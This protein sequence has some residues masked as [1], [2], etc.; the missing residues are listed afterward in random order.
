[1]TY[2]ESEITV[3]Q[4]G[5]AGSPITFS[6]DSPLGAVVAD[7]SWHAFNITGSYITIQ[8]FE[9]YM[10]SPNKASAIIE[11]HGNNISILN[12][13][14][15]DVD[16]GVGAPCWGGGAIDVYEGNSV[17]VTGNRVANAGPAGCVY[18]HTIYVGGSNNY[19]ANNVAYATS[20]WCIH[21]W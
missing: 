17:V 12:N 16:N 21:L 18:M 19:I 5:H 1:G 8:G 6:S 2:T 9:V 4:S 7:H 14:I 11:T 3:S 10:T 20:G 15:H 13:Y